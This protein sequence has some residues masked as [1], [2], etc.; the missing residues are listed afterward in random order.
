[1][2]DDSAIRSILAQVSTATVTTLL[3]KRGV[4]NTWMRG[5]RPL[6]GKNQG[7]VVGR[8]FTMRFVPAREDLATPEALASARSTRA[9]I[10]AM[11]ADCVVVADARGITNAGIFGDILCARMKQRGV[12]AL[13]TDG[14]MR[15]GQGVVQAGLPIWCDG[16]AAPPSISFLTFAGWQETIGCGG[17]AVQ[18]GDL[19]VVDGDGAVVIPPSLLAEV[20]AE[21]PKAEAFEAWVMQRVEA[22]DTL[23]GLYPP[24][25]RTEAEYAAW[26][27]KRG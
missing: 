4:R 13:V 27:A 14:A 20:V 12:A 2:L 18:P 5:P 10:E 6:G 9:A 22:G 21:G 23:P 15:D 8:A 11:P 24:N 25:E 16:I 26:Q 3:L 7:R 19:I 17:V 1:M